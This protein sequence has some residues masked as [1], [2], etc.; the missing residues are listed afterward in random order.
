M[1]L[2]RLFAPLALFA[3][4]VWRGNK[5]LTSGKDERALFAALVVFA[6]LAF[7]CCILV[8]GLGVRSKQQ[9]CC[10]V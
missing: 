4:L 7:L 2:L 5:V 3:L 1:S 8:A 9:R 6:N 10:F